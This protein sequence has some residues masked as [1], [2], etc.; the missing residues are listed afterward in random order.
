MAYAVALPW[1]VLA[2]H[3]GVLLLGTTLAA[4]GIPRTVCIAIGGHASDRWRPWTVMMVAD[5]SRAVAVVAL[6]VVAATGP[7]SAV[8]L[9]PIAVVLGVGEGLFLPGSFSIIPELLPGDKL[10][11]GNALSSSGTQLAT[12]LGPVVGGM[13]VALLGPAPAFGLDSASFVVSAVTLTL[14]RLEQRRARAINE[15][16]VATAAQAAPAFAD[17]GTPIRPPSLLQVL[18]SERVLQVILII[19]VAANLGS[20]GESEVA[21]PALAHGPFHAG[22]VG[23]GALIAVFGTGALVGTLVAGQ[24]STPR[25]PAV[26]ASL[27]FLSEAIFMALVP[28]A[29]G[30]IGAGA[31]LAI[32][33]ALNGFSNVMTITAFQRW[34]PPALLGRL[35][36]LI[37]LTSFGLFPLSVALGAVGVRDLG[38]GAVFPIAAALVA[39]AVLF[40]LSQRAWR[41]FGATMAGQPT[42]TSLAGVEQPEISAANP[43]F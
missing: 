25:R 37:L 31:A 38:P 14:V 33:G 19:N 22:A 3:G 23:F 28:Y 21:L 24:I 41:E 29:G 36:G 20:G 15:E 10:Q 7:P 40:G 12:F 30:V 26:V 32:F 5:T 34:A 16:V 42:Q 4:Y 17:A 27:G 2:D 35:M 9:L 8:M 13:M 1:Y 39:G 6:A 43:P 18:R 11:A